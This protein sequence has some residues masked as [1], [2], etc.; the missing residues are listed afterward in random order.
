MH[1]VLIEF[2]YEIRHW[3]NVQWDE[4]AN[5]GVVSGGTEEDSNSEGGWFSKLFGG[6]MVGNNTE[7]TNGTLLEQLESTMVTTIWNIALEDTDMTWNNLT[8]SGECAGLVVSE[9]DETFVNDDANAE[10]V[11]PKFET[12]LL[13][14][15]VYPVDEVNPDGC[16]NKSDQCTAIHGKISATYSG[17]NEFG[18]SNY[19]INLLSS[20]METG[21]FVSEGGPALMI[22][23]RTASDMSAG[24]N[25]GVVVPIQTD[26]GTIWQVMQEADE[27]SPISKY[28]KLF[29]GLLVVLSVGFIMAS[30]FKKKKSNRRKERAAADVAEDHGSNHL[31]LREEQITEREESLPMKE[32]VS[33]DEEEQSGVAGEPEEGKSVASGWTEWFGGL[34]TKEEPQGQGASKEKERSSTPESVID[35]I[36]LDVPK[37][38]SDEVEVSLGSSEKK[39]WFSK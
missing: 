4:G 7:V 5:A 20:G 9:E 24:E 12:K 13:G 39:G 6:R 38:D 11:A 35:Q 14:L 17:T 28:G 23:F 34:F 32:V 8:L 30:V 36:Q 31:A 19:I 37:S 26:R 18:V 29:V 15:T 22:E 1:N 16:I 10:Y 33:E 27:Q 25:S 21:A 3:S 2:D